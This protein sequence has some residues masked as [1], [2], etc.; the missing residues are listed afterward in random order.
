MNDMSLDFLY[1]DEPSM[2]KAGVLDMKR[3]VQ[4][5]DDMFRTMGEGD[6]LMGSPS[7]NHHGMMLWFPV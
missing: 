2:L 3:C 6:Y 4:S 1:L 7:E 5:I